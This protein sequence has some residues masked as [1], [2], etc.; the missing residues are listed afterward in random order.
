MDIFIST[1]DRQDVFQLPVLPSQIVLNTSSNEII[2]DTVQQGEINLPGLEKL[3]TMSWECHFPIDAR[4][5]S[6]NND[7]FGWDYYEKLKSWKNERMPIR[8]VVTDTPINELFTI[9]ALNPAI[10]TGN[11]DVYYAITLTGFKFLEL[12]KE[13]RS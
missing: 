5:Y 12:E 7:M 10:G 6:K 8:V 4:S 9:S 3:S 13:N 2:Y 1:H 11:G